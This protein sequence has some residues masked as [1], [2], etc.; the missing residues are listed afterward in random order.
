[1]DE[2][3]GELARVEE[4]WRARPPCYAAG[5]SSPAGQPFHTLLQ[6][7]QG[8]ITPL[9]EA[10]V[11]ALDSVHGDGNVGPVAVTLGGITHLGQFW[12]GVP[13]R[14]AIRTA[15][16][17]EPG[18][19]LLH[20]VGH[21]LDHT[22]IEKGAA[23]RST[24]DDPK[25]A[26]WWTAVLDSDLYR[27]LL[28]LSGRDRVLLPRS[29]GTGKEF[30]TLEKRTV[31]DR[32]DR[33]ELFARSYAQYVVVESGDLALRAELDH[34]RKAPGAIMYPEQWPDDD[35]EPIRQALD[36]LIR[37]LGWRT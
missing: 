11:R 18:L 2:R 28:S 37:N 20:E 10:T 22:G 7:E 33:K 16:Q 26:G 9:L 36:G 6:L 27:W 8:K 23:W 21:L 24:A 5:V 35:F 3:L 30:V 19:T 31:R 1:M 34:A 12:P 32:L 29:W 15:R 13:P 25:L 4:G 17:L 14:I